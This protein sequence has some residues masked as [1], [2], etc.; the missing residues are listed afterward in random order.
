MTK[1]WPELRSGWR[2][3]SH[4]KDGYT[5]SPITPKLLLNLFCKND[6]ADMRHDAVAFIGITIEKDP[7]STIVVIDKQLFELKLNNL[8]ISVPVVSK[9]VR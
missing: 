7:Q 6:F 1:C 5:H 4:G 9:K 8:F 2:K 3:G